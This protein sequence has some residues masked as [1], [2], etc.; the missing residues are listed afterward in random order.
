MRWGAGFDSVDVEAASRQGVLVTTTPGANAGAVSELT[1]LLMLAIGRKLLCHTDSLRGG[2]WSKNTF[3]NSSFCLN[4]KLVGI[5]GAGNIGRQVAAKAQAFGASTQYYDLY[6]LSPEMEKEFKLKFVPLQELIATSDIITLHIPLT[7]GKYIIDT[8]EFAQMKDGAIII[9]TSRAGLVNEEALLQAVE[10][11][12][13]AGAGLDVVA[14]EPLA[15]DDPM[16]KNP[17][18]IVTPH[19][20]GGTS[21]IADAIIPM[22]AEDVRAYAA[23]REVLHVVNRELL[24]KHLSL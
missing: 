16:L 4:N 17:N 10:S 5:I 7:D 24:K 12:K 6:R 2:N 18:I 20:G 14:N 23:G 19:I 13:L 8:E 15:A 9:N 1:I 22:L 21:D 3:L 11:G